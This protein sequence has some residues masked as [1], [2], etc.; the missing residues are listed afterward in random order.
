MGR[1]NKPIL[2]SFL[3]KGEHE[4]AARFTAEKTGELT[5][6]LVYWEVFRRAWPGPKPII[7]N[8]DGA[9]VLPAHTKW[10]QRVELTHKVAV[11]Q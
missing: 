4:V 8:P 3:G 7:W 10:S 5:V 1:Q 2:A 6:R 9:P 11:K